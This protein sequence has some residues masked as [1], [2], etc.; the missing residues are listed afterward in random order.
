MT[1]IA[2]I[3]L[4]EEAQWFRDMFKDYAQLP[5][6]MTVGTGLLLGLL[7]VWLGWTQPSGPM[8]SVLTSE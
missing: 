2:G 8:G 7:A 3:Y 6:V 1:Q 5:S 4:L